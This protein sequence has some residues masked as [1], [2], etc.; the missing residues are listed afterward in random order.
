MLV[1]NVFGSGEGEGDLDGLQA[2]DTEQ[3]ATGHACSIAADPHC[4]SHQSFENPSQLDMKFPSS[5]GTQHVGHNNL[6]K[7]QLV[8]HHTSVKGSQVATYGTVVGRGVGTV[9]P[10][11]THEQHCKGHN[12]GS[13]VHI[14]VHH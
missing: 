6:A 11:S 12:D 10:G 2:P 14:P 7:L 9:V 5:F 4:E 3:H 8:V 1:P 13:S